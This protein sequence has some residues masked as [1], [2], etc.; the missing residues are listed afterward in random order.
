MRATD[1][2]E[3]FE[4]LNLCY[5]TLMRPLPGPDS[6]KLWENLLIDHPIDKVS[7]AFYRHMQTSKFPPMPA[8]ILAFLTP[9][10]ENDGRPNA[11]EAWVVALAGNDERASVRWTSETAQALTSD[12]KYL[13]EHDEIGARMAF[14]AIYAR[15]CREARAA[16]RPVQWN[17]SLGYDVGGREPIVREAL[18]DGL[19]THEQAAMQV[20]QLGAPTTNVDPDKARVCRETIAR[21]LA[22]MPSATEKLAKANTERAER[23]RKRMEQAKQVTAQRVAAYEANHG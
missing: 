3:F 6:I 17:V 21:T 9:N 5:S 7:A 1:R 10:E 8:D 12:V 20:P 16:R 13:L 4:L 14:K 22:G 11:D 2:T 23:E 19:L 18:R 15:L